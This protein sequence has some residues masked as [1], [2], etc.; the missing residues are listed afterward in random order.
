MDWLL[1]A[2]LIT[3]PVPEETPEVLGKIFPVEL[4]GE[5]SESV[6]KLALEWEILDPRE[7]RYVMNYTHDIKEF[8]NDLLVLRNRYQLLKDAP[9]LIECER[10][11]PHAHLTERLT[12]NRQYR[13]YIGTCMT[14]DPIQASLYRVI[15][16]ETDDIYKIWDRVRDCRC[17]YYYITV[18]RLAL[19]DL[20]DWLEN[21]DYCTGTLPM[22]V[23]LWRFTEE[24]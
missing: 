20:K 23:P 24:K 13:R 19:K 16:K 7:A 18:R 5:L 6:Q 11:P 1:A 10:W 14:S 3:T 9:P 12:F 2:M 4:N 8:Y 22:H 21:E 15:L 17:E